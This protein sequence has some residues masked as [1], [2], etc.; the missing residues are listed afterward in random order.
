MNNIFSI[1]RLGQLTKRH[2]ILNYNRM[3][4]EV[5]GSIGLLSVIGAIS[6]RQAS[7]P[8]NAL[9]LFFFY[10]ILFV[11]GFILTSN[12]FHELHKP[13]K[14]IQYMTLPA[15]NL[16]KLISAWLNSS[17]LILA[18]SLVVYYAS[19]ILAKLLAL[20]WFDIEMPIFNIFVFFKKVCI[21]YISIHSLFFFGAVYFK[22]KNFFKTLF[23]V[24]LLVL[25]F[26]IYHSIIGAT[27]TKEIITLVMEEN[28]VNPGEIITAPGLKEYVEGTLFP[29]L[30]IIFR[31]ILPIFFIVL[32][33][34]GLKEREV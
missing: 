34:I 19:F 14:S 27:A 3:F 31:Y 16:E 20:W 26:S 22:G 25:F 30:K 4:L 13:E 29:I 32:S 21:A 23:S 18:L 9:F 33:Y 10:A 1:A 8:N 11:G 7:F 24:F 6:F 28:T 12:I 5:T 2:L 17:V 15:S